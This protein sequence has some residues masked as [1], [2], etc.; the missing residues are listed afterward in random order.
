MASCGPGFRP[1]RRGCGTPGSPRRSARTQPAGPCGPPGCAAGRRARP[2]G[3]GAGSGRAGGGLD[4][5]R[6][7][8]L[9][10]AM[11]QHRPA[12]RGSEVAY[13]VHVGAE[14]RDQVPLAVDVGDRDWNEMTRPL[15]CPVISSAAA[16]P[17]AIPAAE[18][19]RR[20]AVLQ[21][22]ETNSGDCLGTATAGSRRTASWPPS[23]P[24]PG[25]PRQPP[26][27][28]DLPDMPA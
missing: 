19:D 5:L 11:T 16:R 26:A 9:A 18:R 15:C 13:P 3:S 17:G 20:G 14:H 21:P 24:V 22:G 2:A 7:R 25:L 12:A 6:V 27:R 8:A 4:F 28:A 23:S 10:A 1:G